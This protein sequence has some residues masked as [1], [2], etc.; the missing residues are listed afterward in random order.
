MLSFISQNVKDEIANGTN[1]FYMR[2]VSTN[3]WKTSNGEK[4]FKRFEN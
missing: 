1:C 2:A 3:T 4:N